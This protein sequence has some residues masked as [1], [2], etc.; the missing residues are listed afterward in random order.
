MGNLVITSFWKLA[1]EKRIKS[2]KEYKDTKHEASLVAELD[3]SAGDDEVLVLDH[4]MV[5]GPSG[6]WIVDSGATSHMCTARERFSDYNL[7]QNLGRVSVG[8]GRVLKVVGCGKVHLLMRLPGDKV[9]RCVLHMMFYMSQT[10]HVTLYESQR[11]LKR[12]RQPS[13]MSLDVY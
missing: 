6:S 2:Q 7:L 11:Q 10:S 9:K 4:A 5:V 12:P 8:D 1:A 13:L 3:D